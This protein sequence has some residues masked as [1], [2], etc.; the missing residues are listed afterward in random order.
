MEGAMLKQTA[1]YATLVSMMMVGASLAQTTETP[2]DVP[3]P[4]PLGAPQQQIN[5][6]AGFTYPA[7]GPAE[8]RRMGARSTE[9]LLTEIVTWLSSNFELPA[10]H[11]HPRV[12]FVSTAKLINMRYR[13][14]LAE[15]PRAIGV[16]EPAVQ[17]AQ[18]REVVAVYNAATKTIFLGEGW[19]G[20]TPA[21]LSVLVHEMVHHLQNLGALKY[22]CPAAREK[23][24]YLAQNK[25]LKQFGLDLETEFEVDMFTVVV[26]SACMD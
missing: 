22:D 5:Q 4:V 16:N 20:T 7:S 9:A 3:M 18:Q 23:P 21:E 12:E 17:V 2:N 14:F 25:W 26:T 15:G 11:D 19:T 10:L 8:F 6:V 24:A 13:G 1:V